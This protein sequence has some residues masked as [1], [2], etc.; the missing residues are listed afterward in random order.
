MGRTWTTPWH[1]IRRASLRFLTAGICI[2]GAA[3]VVLAAPGARTVTIKP[4]TSPIRIDGVLDEPAWKD[5]ARVSLPYEVQPGDNIPAPVRTECLITYDRH[6]LYVAFRAFDPEPKKIRAHLADRDTPFDDDFVGIILDTYHDGRRG[7]EFFVNPFGVQMDLINN[8]VGGG[9]DASWDA[10]WDSKGRITPSG[11]VVEMAIPFS[12]LRF[13]KTRTAQTWGFSALRVYPRDRRYLLTSEP[14]DRNRSCELCQISELTG[15]EGIQPGHDIEFDPTF[16]ATG[17]ENRDTFPGGTLSDPSVQGNAGLTGHWGIT[18]NLT[19]TGTINPDFSQVEADAAQLSINRTFTLY[20]PEKRPFFLEGSDYFDTPINVLHTRMI[21]DP[22]W[23]AKLTGKT[24]P[25]ALGLFVAQDDLTNIIF[26]G[27]QG[28]SSGSFG[29]GNTSAVVRYR[30]DIGTSS[31]LG[32]IATSREGGGYSNQV[33]GVD[34]LLRVTAADSVKF[35]LLGS[36][37][38]YP[39]AIAADYGEPDHSFNGSASFLRYSHDTKYW[40]WSLQYTDYE[41][42]FRADLGF[43]P[44]VDTRF[45]KA[46]AGHTWW[47]KPGAFLSRFQLGVNWD[48]T[49][50]HNGLALDRR[51]EIWAMASGPWQSQAMINVGT[52]KTFY[53]GQLFD[54]DYAEM[55]INARPSGSLSIGT[56]LRFGDS[57]DYANTRSADGLT[58]RPRITLKLGRHVQMNVRHTYEQMHVDGGRLYRANLT[59]FRIVYQLNVRTFVRLVTQYTDI[60]RNPALYSF[61][62]E[63]TSRQLFNQLLFSYKVNPQTMLFLGY[64]DSS[65][66]QHRIDM[67]TM[68]R[69]IFFKIGYAWLL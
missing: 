54:Q 43:V 38:S 3:S 42:G 8:D 28:S 57:I 19:L 12:S 13:P 55:F 36:Q 68:N 50:D 46:L 4:A 69:T 23:G 61:Q 10:I 39:Q 33:Y 49:R 60:A 7:F 48:E 1:M 26:P 5:A 52:A 34:G 18:P 17:A 30:R 67:T 41:R 58:L 40:N 63:P 37:T 66:G 31:V 27:N 20:Y 15:L 65:I 9:E 29:F 21:A 53:N 25:N 44:R 16:T 45:V 51:S 2:T 14:R 6:H 35:Q 62:V 11:Y 24:G 47:G 64:S 32:A 59:D 22:S 56:F